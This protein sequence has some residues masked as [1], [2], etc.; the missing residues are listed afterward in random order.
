MPP[1]LPTS[2]AE[3]F[4]LLILTQF[5]S[6]HLFFSLVIYFFLLF[7]DPF[8][9]SF[10]FSGF[11]H[12]EISIFSFEECGRF[13]FEP[14]GLNDRHVSSILEL[15]IFVGVIRLFI[16]KVRCW[17]EIVVFPM[18]GR[19]KVCLSYPLPPPILLLCSIAG[20]KVHRWFHRLRASFLLEKAEG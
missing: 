7:I 13:I 1:L 14:N 3:C 6:L 9:M 16:V 12:T 10:T 2:T 15:A 8:T 5:Q 17:I 19:G 20:T 18:R 11:L 4:P